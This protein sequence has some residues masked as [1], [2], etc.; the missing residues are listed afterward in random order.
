MHIVSNAD[1]FLQDYSYKTGPFPLHFELVVTPV[2]CCTY[3][4]PD[5]VSF[6]HIRTHILWLTYICHMK[7]DNFTGVVELGGLELGGKVLGMS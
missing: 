1:V 2:M 3:T 4:Y 5:K 6:T 7:E